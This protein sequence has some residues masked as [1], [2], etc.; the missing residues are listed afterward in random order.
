[1]LGNSRVP[2]CPFTGQW[3]GFPIDFV[4]T[5]KETLEFQIVPS[6]YNGQDSPL[7]SFRQILPS[8]ISLTVTFH[9]FRRTVQRP[10]FKSVF[11]AIKVEV[12]NLSIRTFRTV[13]GDQFFC[14]VHAALRLL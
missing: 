1:M 11:Y 10:S 7:L 5:G 14:P 8:L 6:L 4:S 12:K 9:T 13:T 2:D 3:A